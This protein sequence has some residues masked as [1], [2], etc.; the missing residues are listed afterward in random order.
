[1]SENERPSEDRPEPPAGRP[2]AA[3]RRLGRYVIPLVVLG[4]AAFVIAFMLLV[5]QCGTDAEGSV[6]ARGSGAA[7]VVELHGP[8]VP[9][10]A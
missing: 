8:G 2:T 5:S 4:A 3:G 9:A 10:P 7:P 1:M 6:H